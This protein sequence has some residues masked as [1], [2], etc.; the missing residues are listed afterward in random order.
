MGQHSPLGIHD[1]AV[2]QY[3]EDLQDN[4]SFIVLI[5]WGHVLDRQRP[6]RGEIVPIGP[7]TRL[8]LTET[9]HKLREAK[10][11]FYSA[12]THRHTHART[13]GR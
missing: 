13:R 10:V 5:N 8:G 6:V 2:K 1:Q 4:I 7:A 12:R 9:T 3:L 11:F